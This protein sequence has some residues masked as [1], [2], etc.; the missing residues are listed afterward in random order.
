MLTDIQIKSMSKKMGLPLGGVV[1][2]TEL[3][4]M[5]LEY[6]KTYI[7]NLE[8]ETDENGD[9][10]EGSHYVF[11]QMNK[12]PHG[13]FS[14]IYFDSYGKIYP[15]VVGNIVKK[16]CNDMVCPYTTKDIQ[17]IVSGMCGW[18]CM[19]LSFY[20]NRFP[21]RTYNIYDDVGCF[22]SFFNDLNVSNDHKQNEWVLSQFFQPK[23]GPKREFNFGIV[24]VVKKDLA[25]GEKIIEKEGNGLI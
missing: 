17:S 5:K 22:L 10:N 18:Y 9:R 19:A 11:L 21:Q 24:D 15:V 3:P 7:I 1:F 23:N 2:K 8:D 25:E 13:N 6:N 16:Y 12:S 14:P 4:K 20:L